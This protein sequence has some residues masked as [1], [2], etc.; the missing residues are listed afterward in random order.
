M[1][2]DETR[3]LTADRRI[4]ILSASA[5]VIGERG[6]DGTRLSDVGE[7]VG[8][9]ASNISYYFGSKERLL[10]ETI[11]W[12]DETYYSLL[13]TEFTRLSG[14]KERL[15][16]M[17]ERVFPKSRALPSDWALWLE[18]QLR[19]TRDP[20]FTELGRRLDRRWMSTLT[21]LVRDGVNA[22][23]FRCDDIDNFV[24]AFA[25]LVDGLATRVLSGFGPSQKQAVRV[26][27][28]FAREQLDF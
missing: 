13:F 14:P 22:G 17:I 24:V 9:T 2:K 26:C 7:A 21:G 1:T 3:E 18:V 23:E 8:M 11:E 10:S 12:A 20:E 6:L 16:H 28:G 27:L 19:A 5:R 4:Q 15:V 25:A